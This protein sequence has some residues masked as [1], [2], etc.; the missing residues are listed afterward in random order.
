MTRQRQKPRADHI[1]DRIAEGASTNP[2][3][4]PKTPP[5]VTKTQPKPTENKGK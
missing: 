2:N 3:K 1:P 4:A 5:P